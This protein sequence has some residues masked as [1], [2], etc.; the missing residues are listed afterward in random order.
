MGA[1]GKFLALV[2]AAFFL[3]HASVV[4]A[5]GGEPKWLS[6]GLSPVRVE[7]GM[8][9]APGEERKVVLSVVNL[10]D[11]PCEVEVKAEEPP[12]GVLR[13][14]ER[15]APPE[16]VLCEPGVL[17]LEPRQ[18]EFVAVT[19]KP[20]TATFGDYTAAV[21]AR[22]SLPGGGTRVSV[23]SYSTV[24]F[25]VDPMAGLKR[26]TVKFGP[27]VLVLSVLA[28]YMVWRKKKLRGLKNS[29]DS[30]HSG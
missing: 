17:M 15:V 12:S 28:A 30:Y 11:V 2:A 20:G 29:D 16:W 21:A 14:G 1:I 27:L 18:S 13:D 26:A 22:A 8:P 4:P 3:L 9:V 25:R 5:D 6:A 19:V 23:V 10:G 7:M 24:K